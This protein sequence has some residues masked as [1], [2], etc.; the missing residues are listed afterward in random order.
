MAPMRATTGGRLRAVGLAAAVVVWALPLG[1]CTGDSGEPKPPEG[2]PESV[3]LELSLGPG[4]DG[5]ATDARD[6]L[7]ND[8]GAALST[9]VVEAFLGDYPR[10]DF[11]TALDTFTSGVTRDAATDIEQITGAGFKNADDVVAT[12]LL[13]NISTFAPGQEAVGV[14][15][16]VDF[17]FDVRE[18]DTTREVTLR[19]RLMLMP[20]DGQWK[21][22]GYDV[23]TDDPAAGGVS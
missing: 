15:A 20:V 3:A 1:A 5:L 9:Y 18:H 7:Q 14:T 21:I 11:V 6:D 22:F 23:Q 10:D 12:R 13:A 2:H 19:G 4:A 17:A 8:V 16:H